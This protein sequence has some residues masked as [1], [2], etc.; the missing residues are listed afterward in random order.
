MK[1][2]LIDVALNQ[3]LDIWLD[4]FRTVGDKLLCPVFCQQLDEDVDECCTALLTLPDK[5]TESLVDRQ[6]LLEVG[7]SMKPFPFAQ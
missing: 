3:L 2:G 7:A 5:L 4:G 1:N 6:R